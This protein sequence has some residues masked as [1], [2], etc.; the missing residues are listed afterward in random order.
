MSTQERTDTEIKNL[1]D[2]FNIPHCES[3]HEQ[4]PLSECSHTATHIAIVP[5]Q[6]PKDI[7]VCTNLVIAKQQYMR[8]GRV[9]GQCGRLAYTH[10]RYDSL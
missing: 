10:W 8:E 9:C 7:L 1:E 3:A 2:A 6:F 4:K 5:C